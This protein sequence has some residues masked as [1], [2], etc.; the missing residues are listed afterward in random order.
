ML[1]KHWFFS[2]FGVPVFG[3]G[4]RGS[5]GWDKIPTFANF[6]W[7]SPKFHFLFSTPD[8][9]TVPTQKLDRCL[10]LKN[11]LSE[12]WKIIY[13][14]YIATL[15]EKSHYVEQSCVPNQIK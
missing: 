9:L 8:S 5:A 10:C 2:D 12:N 11:S 1:N 3:E 14:G 4:G 13:V 7:G 15:F 6:F